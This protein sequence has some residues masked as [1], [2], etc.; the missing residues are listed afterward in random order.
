MVAKCLSRQTYDGEVEWLVSTPYKPPEP[1]I[2]V[3]TTP[4]GDYHYALNRDWNKLYR[5]A[6]GELIVN[7]VDLLW[8]PPDMLEKFW[9][10]YQSNPKALV[11]TI[12]HQYDQMVDGKPENKM[13]SDPRAR[14][15]QGSYWE[16]F[17][18]DMEMCVASIPR[19]AI[20]DCKGLKEKYDYGAALSEKEMCFRLDTMGYK[21]YLDSTIEYRALHHER[22][23]GT[24]SWDKHYKIACDMFAEDMAKI[25]G[26]QELIGD[27]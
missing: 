18:Q 7:I 17:P 25:R 16:I 21:F 13:W 26:G 11:T 20:I 1:A 4:K 12:G 5:K 23:G 9:Y 14:L 8:F 15:D 3:G 2:Q 10:H 27:L 6:Q 19:Q 24:E 22:I